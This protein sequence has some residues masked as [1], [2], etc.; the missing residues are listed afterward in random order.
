MVHSFRYI[1]K[2][3]VSLKIASRNPSMLSTVYGRS[4]VVVQ[5]NVVRASCRSGMVK[6]CS[7]TGAFVSC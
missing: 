2:A 7:R 3:V 1:K 5:T 6:S 4:V